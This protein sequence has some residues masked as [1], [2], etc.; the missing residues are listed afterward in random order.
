M[1]TSSKDASLWAGTPISSRKSTA[2]E[3]N[4]VENNSIPQSSASNPD[5]VPAA[6]YGHGI[7]R[8]GLELDGIG[9][10]VLGRVNDFYRLVDALVMVGGHFRDHVYRMA[11][12]DHSSA[13]VDLCWHAHKFRGRTERINSKASAAS[14]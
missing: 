3:S 11:V 5:L 12:T 4:G 8:I 14:H 7:R 13:D 6:V 1:S 10:S 2:V 9:A